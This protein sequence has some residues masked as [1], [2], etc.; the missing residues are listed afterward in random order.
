MS[1]LSCC[2][3]YLL[4]FVFISELLRL[5]ST[6]FL[7][8]FLDK[9]QKRSN[10]PRNVWAFKFTCFGLFFKPFFYVTVYLCFKSAI[11]LLAF[12]YIFFHPPLVY[13][14]FY[15]LPA[16]PPESFGLAGDFA[17]FPEEILVGRGEKTELNLNF[18]IF[19]FKKWQ[20][21]RFSRFWKKPVKLT[22]TLICQINWAPL[23]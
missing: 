10:F 22:N 7:I 18:K 3:W 16:P 1:Y 19:V 21:G 8:Y 11:F 4:F 9:F 23:W 2:A 20:N 5:V 12:L 6:F 14:F 17:I 13:C 15:R